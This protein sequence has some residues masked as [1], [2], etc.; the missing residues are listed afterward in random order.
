MV[1]TTDTTEIVTQP[2]L[3][4]S[5]QPS[6]KRWLKHFFYMPATKRFFSKQDQHAIALAVEEAEHGHVGEIQVVIEGCLPSRSAYY[7]NT[8]CRARQ[9]FAELGVWD[10]EYNS[11]VLL[12]L[13]LC[14]R[15]VE[16]VIDRGI[17]Q[18]TTQE[19]WN[20]ICQ[21]IIQNLARQ[22]YK[23]GVIEGIQQIG[24]V[25]DQYYD[26]KIADVENELGNKPILLG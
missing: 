8:L 17:R 15:K 11:G 22:Q 21:S 14:E 24:Q 1:T 2:K 3:E 18:A 20:E 13:N 26:R 9:L 23:H 7:Q 16:I 4:Q 6:F 12:Y 10:T 25:L 19:I 5:V